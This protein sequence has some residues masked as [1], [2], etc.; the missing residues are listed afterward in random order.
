MIAVDISQIQ[1]WNQF[2]VAATYNFTRQFLNNNEAHHAQ[3]NSS[4]TM[5]TGSPELK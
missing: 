1:H 3:L 5:P 2:E 4:D